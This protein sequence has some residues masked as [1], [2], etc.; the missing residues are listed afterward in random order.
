MTQYAKKTDIPEIDTSDFVSK[1]A[2]NVTT[3][4]FG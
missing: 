1:T 4:G 2:T 3:G